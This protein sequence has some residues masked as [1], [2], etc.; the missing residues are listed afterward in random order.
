MG[1]RWREDR[2]TA[3]GLGARGPRAVTKRRPRGQS[4]KRGGC[5]RQ[6]REEGARGY[7]RERATTRGNETGEAGNELRPG[8]MTEWLGNA[9]RYRG[10]VQS[11]ERDRS[12]V[13]LRAG[14][15]AS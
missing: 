6:A 3:K 12:T 1:G 13:G 5:Y 14:L 7:G 10:R 8:N 9:R 2:K 11:R 15:R 4:N